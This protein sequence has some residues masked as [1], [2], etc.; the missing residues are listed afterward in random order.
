MPD[1]A[2]IRRTAREALG[3]MSVV[4]VREWGLLARLLRDGEEIEAMVLSRRK[5][6]GLVG[7]QRVVVATPDRLLLVEKGFVSGRER[8]EQY[9]WDEVLGV[10][11]HP[12]ARL[13]LSLREGQVTL[14]FVQPPRALGAV[15]D[16]IRRHLD[17]GATEGVTTGELLDLTRRKLGRMLAFG[18]E[19]NVLVLAQE[20]EPS[21]SVLEL[22]WVADKPSGLLALTDRRLV[23]VPST[24][25]GTGEPVSVPDAAMTGIALDEEGTLTAGGHAWRTVGPEERVQA[26]VQRVAARLPS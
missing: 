11:V 20:L 5:G 17:P 7:S 22:A 16:V 25:I 26:L 6:A 1:R 12:P 24:R 3:R 10:R 8:I 18:A 14:T 13:E 15:A 2:A 4:G 23:F 21:E 9:R 19:E